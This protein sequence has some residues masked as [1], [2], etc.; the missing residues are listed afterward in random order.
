MRGR[1]PL[2]LR[3]VEDLLHERGIDISHE[4]V[5]FWWNRFGLMF[6]AEIRRKRI[7]QLRGHCQKKLGCEGE[8]ADLAFS[9]DKTLAISLLQNQPGNHS[10]GGDDVRSISAVTSQCRGPA[11]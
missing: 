6:A 5:R 9:H 2:S 8:G 4:S 10:P 3:N 11:G 7:Q 1:F